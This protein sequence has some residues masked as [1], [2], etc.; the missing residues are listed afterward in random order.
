MAIQSNNLEELI[1]KIKTKRYTYTRIQRIL[2]KTLFNIQHAYKAYEPRYVRFLGFNQKG[3][4]LI[5]QIKEASP[6]DVITNLRNFEPK[7]SIAR[8]MIALDIKATN[9]YQL[10]STPQHKRGGQDYL[11]KPIIKT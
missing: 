2:F 9:I 3:M 6:L 10:F 5:N 1:N 4:Q 11:K 8:D 7:D